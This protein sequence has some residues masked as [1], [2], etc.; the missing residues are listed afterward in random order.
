MKPAELLFITPRNLPTV[1]SNEYYPTEAHYRKRNPVRWMAELHKK[2]AAFIALALLLSMITG[3]LYS[4]PNIILPEA[5]GVVEI[6]TLFVLIILLGGIAAVLL[7]TILQEV[8]PCILSNEPFYTD[9][10]KWRSSGGWVVAYE[11]IP[12]VKEKRVGDRVYVT[13]VKEDFQKLA[14]YVDNADMVI[15]KQRYIIRALRE[16]QNMLDKR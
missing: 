6:G 5:E 13:M 4:I 11:H 16:Q 10:S 7:G 2:G 3:T 9:A 14:E 15:I 12:G 1:S 8:L